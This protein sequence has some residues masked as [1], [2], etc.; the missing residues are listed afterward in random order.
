MRADDDY[1]PVELWHE[2][3]QFISDISDDVNIFR[4][5]CVFEKNIEDEAAKFAAWWDLERYTQKPHS[6][7]LIYENLKNI[8]DEVGQ[9]DI[10]D[11]FATL[12][13]SMKAL[14]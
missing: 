7:I 6:L 2:A 10:L 8:W 1:I 9:Y 12:L 14:R 13:A 3:K 11:G 5:F 4:Q